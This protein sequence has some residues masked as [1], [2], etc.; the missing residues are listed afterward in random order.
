MLKIGTLTNK[1]ALFEK[2]KKRWK[3]AYS[4]G[5][6]RAQ[7]IHTVQKTGPGN[8][9]SSYLVKRVEEIEDKK[10]G[11]G[12]IEDIAYSMGYNSHHATLEFAVND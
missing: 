12:L 10:K 1:M 8:T 9:V 11:Y 3:E 6:E 2:T 5:Y 7:I 4:A